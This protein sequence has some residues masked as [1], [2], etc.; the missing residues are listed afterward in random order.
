[1]AEVIRIE[2]AYA[3]PDRQFL[4][5]FELQFGATVADAIKASG[6]EIE[7]SIDVSTLSA[8]IWSKPV[9]PETQ[10][11]DGDRVELYRPLRIDP[12]DARRKRAK[13][14]PA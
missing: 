7:F 11:D 2:V 8:G 10:L 9:L 6:I 3:E 14:R 1:M 4:R 13:K 12:M 5:A